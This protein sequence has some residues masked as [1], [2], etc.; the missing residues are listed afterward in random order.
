MKTHLAL[1]IF[2][3]WSNVM[4]GC[5]CSSLCVT[6]SKRV[7]SRLYPLKSNLVAIH[8]RLYKSR[9]KI[10]RR[11]NVSSHSPIVKQRSGNV[12][13]I[14]WPTLTMRVQLTIGMHSR[15]SQLGCNTCAAE[16]E[17]FSGVKGL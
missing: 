2:T 3:S 7:S 8:Y 12:V 14:D 13:R 17:M 15:R 10:N 16:I 4:Y 11:V 5:K 6:A 9:A 1:S